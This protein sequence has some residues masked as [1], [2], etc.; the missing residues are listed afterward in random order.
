MSTKSNSV[1]IGAFVVGAVALLAAGVA[2]FGGAQYFTTKSQLVAY[3]E[4]SVKGLR[5]GSNVLFRGVRIGYVSEIQL[6][7]DVA[8]FSPIV[9]TTLELSPE[10]FVLYDDSERLPDA[11]DVMLT[12]EQLVE[13]GLRARL[14]TESFVTG[15][16]V[17]ELD[18]LPDSE[19]VMR[20][21][22]DEPL[23]EI[24]TVP[25]DVQ[26]I[27][28]ELQKFVQGID[29]EELAQNLQRGMAGLDELANS[30]DA[31]GALSG[32][33]TF[34]NDQDFQ[35]LPAMLRSSLAEV[36]GAATRIG[37]LAADVDAEVGPL[38]ADLDTA[39]NKLVGTLDSA[40]STLDTL[41]RQIGG[42]T[43]L[44]YE[45]SA[46]LR[47]VRET[48]RSL[49]VLTDYLQNNPEALIRGKN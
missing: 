1:V 19:A 15:Q 41:D 47:E 25:T 35:R 13:A 18:F 10:T 36:R 40:Q 34:T 30:E 46:T 43:G 20:A 17:V 4:G 9:R 16:L 31:R 29:F 11:T 14:G 5:V 24:P 8:T 2:L 22:K 42:D 44:E 32:L 27:L 26:Q 37:E 33:N 3:F 12:A 48:A 21:R 38:A 7:G 23:R 39:L 49:R 6:L 45:V 28:A